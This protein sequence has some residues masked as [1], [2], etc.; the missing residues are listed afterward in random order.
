MLSKTRIG[1]FTSS[2]IYNLMKKGRGNNPSVATQTYIDE[3]VMEQ[4]LERSLNA[5]LSSRPT[6][7]G[8]MV[9]KY[10][11]SKLDQ[12]EYEYCSDQS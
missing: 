10:V 11:V 5:D 7:W 2:G 4:R 6:T 9:E 1:R 3:K 8:H 12:F